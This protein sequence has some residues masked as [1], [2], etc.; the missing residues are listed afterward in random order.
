MPPPPPPPRRPKSGSGPEAVRMK[1]CLDVVLDI[2]YNLDVM[3]LAYVSWFIDFVKMYV[4]LRRT[5]YVLTLTKTITAYFQDKYRDYILIIV[6]NDLVEQSISG[7]H[8]GYHPEKF[9]VHSLLKTS[10]VSPLIILHDLMTK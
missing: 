3:S 10:E 7:D 5:F 4:K 1:S 9:D 6:T 2:L 8:F